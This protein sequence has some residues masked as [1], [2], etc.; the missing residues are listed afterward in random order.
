MDGTLL[1]R[2]WGGKNISLEDKPHHSYSAHHRSHTFGLGLSTHLRDEGLTTLTALE[3]PRLLSSYLRTIT[4]HKT[5]AVILTKCNT[6][7]YVKQE[8]KGWFKRR[9][10]TRFAYKLKSE[11]SLYH[12]FCGGKAISIV[13]SECVFVTLAI[14]NAIVCGLSPS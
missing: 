11:A 9:K 8:H 4:I 2:Y 14:Q 3:T 5:Q 7:C 10:H 6:T 12:Y 1:G 13:Y